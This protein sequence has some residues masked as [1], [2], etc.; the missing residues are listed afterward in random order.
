MNIKMI[1]IQDKQKGKEMKNK[2]QRVLALCDAVDSIISYRSYDEPRSSE[3]A[4][5]ELRWQFNS[6]LVEEAVEIRQ[7]MNL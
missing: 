4:I 3:E 1:L 2:L 5:K 6:Q 7:S